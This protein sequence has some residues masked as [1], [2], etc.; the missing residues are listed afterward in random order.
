MDQHII[1]GCVYGKCGAKKREGQ[2]DNIW[3]MVPEMIPINTLPTHYTH[4]VL[5]WQAPQTTMTEI[6]LTA[7]V[8]GAALPRVVHQHR[9]GKR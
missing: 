4:C 5:M 8:W 7:G 3:L 2:R 6:P 1:K 9:A